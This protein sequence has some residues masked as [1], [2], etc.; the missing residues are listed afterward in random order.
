MANSIQS[1]IVSN[2][3]CT[4]LTKLFA[5]FNVRK[6]A[7]LEEKI[8]G[9]MDTDLRESVES[10]RAVWTEWEQFLNDLDIEIERVCGPIQGGLDPIPLKTTRN[11][12]VQS[13]TLLAYVKSCAYDLLFIQVVTSFATHEASELVLK[14]YE[15][16]KSFQELN[17]DILLLTKGSSSGGHGFLKLVGVPF[18]TLLD[19]EESLS[20]IL[21]HRQSAVSL[22]GEKA[23]R[24]FTEIILNDE[25]LEIHGDTDDHGLGALGGCILVDKVGN[26]LYSYTCTDNNSWPDVEILLE[27]VKINSTGNPS[28]RNP[29]P[30]GS[31]KKSGDTKNV[32]DSTVFSDA[33]TKD[34]DLNVAVTKKK[35]CTIL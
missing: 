23:I 6:S 28:S 11:R 8:K 4:N 15:K 20:R 27:Q 30:S 2:E 24:L 5:A 22:A 9:L 14:S 18:R 16:L 1:R 10:L 25:T 7:D 19:E 33:T 13:G 17:C 31:S 26:I 35:C 21:Q 12:Q 34:E 3:L 32:A 29:T